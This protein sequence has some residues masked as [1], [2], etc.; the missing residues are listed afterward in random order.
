M[1]D[2]VPRGMSLLVDIWKPQLGMASSSPSSSKNKDASIIAVRCATLWMEWISK[3]GGKE[4]SNTNIDNAS[5]QQTKELFVKMISDFDDPLQQLTLVD[6]LVQYFGT[7]AN[8]L[9]SDGPTTSSPL[10]L[11]QDSFLASPEL[12]SPIFQMMQD[13]LLSGSALQY[14]TCVLSRLRPNEVDMVLQH[15]R[16]CG[17]VTSNESER[18]QIVQA[19]SNI[20]VTMDPK[21]ILQDQQ[22]RHSWWDVT[23]V[24]QSKL[25]A[26]I[27]TSIALTL[28]KLRN[29]KAAASMYNAVGPD[30]NST[31]D[32]TEWLWNRY[33]SSPMEELRIAAYALLAAMLQLST[34]GM[35]LTMHCNVKQQLVELVTDPNKRESTFDARLA[36]YDVI[37]KFYQH[38]TSTSSSVW[39]TATLNENQISKLQDQLQ[40]KLRLGPHG[41][42]P[43]RWDV[44]TE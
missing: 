43:Q 36:Y 41:R 39:M 24:S 6:L 19:L 29:D 38:V 23:R 20:A 37:E 13:P 26:A 16:Q 35:I 12:L 33:L 21:I 25:Q 1:S 28:P 31:M 15:I 8:T 11:L 32:T 22:L 10:S 5:F 42:E 4:H 7:D 18:L 14:L 40:K 44:A 30:N 9:T 17:V 27:L 2:I 3:L 34:A